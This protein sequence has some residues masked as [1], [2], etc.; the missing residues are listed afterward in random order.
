MRVEASLRHELH[1]DVVRLALHLTTFSNIQQR[2]NYSTI[3][4]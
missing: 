1:P 2:Q 3:L 4:L